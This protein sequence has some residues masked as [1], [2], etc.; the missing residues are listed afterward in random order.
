MILPLSG[1]SYLV[2]R[3][4]FA[5]MV[6][7]QEFSRRW[8]AWFM[9]MLVPFLAHNVW[10]YVFATAALLYVLRE[11]EVNA[12][13]L[14]FMLLFA[15]PTFRIEIPG[16]GMVNYL[17]HINH[18]RLLALLVLLP[19]FIWLRR[20]EGVAPVG[21]FLADKLIIAFIAYT[22]LMTL[23]GTT[24]TDTIRAAFLWFIDIFLP[25]YVAS[26]AV[27]SRAE[28]REVLLAFVFG[29]MAVS[30]VAFFE[31]LKGWLV[32]SPLSIALQAPMGMGD[33]VLRG[34]AV[35]ASATIGHPIALGYV[36]MVA[37]GMLFFLRSYLHDSFRRRAVFLLL[38]AGIFAA[39]SRGPWVGACVFLL[40]FALF[41]ER[42]AQALLKLLLGFMLAGIA[43]LLLPGG[44]K[45]IDMLP[46][47]GTVDAE[48]VEYRERLLEN[49]LVVIARNPWFGSVNYLQ[50]PEMISMFQGQG[51]IDVVN[52]YLQI[53]LEFGYVGLAL[54]VGFFLVVLQGVRGRFSSF[55]AFDREGRVL[56][57]MLFAV[58]A[59]TLV[60]IY[61]T[62]SIL[63]IPIVYW[64]LAGL[65]VAYLSQT[66]HRPA[67]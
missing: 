19:A 47:V 8:G 27:R 46:Y 14:Y 9:V 23:R 1:M 3:T 4:A 51:I 61:T 16:F 44:E 5:N 60:V 18:P 20:Q 28:M 17:F 6:L 65:G 59:A 30:M 26:R 64:S 31:N 7:P 66:M 45:L 57:A 37:L 63:S 54:F 39:M 42:P 41:D 13:A 35:R 40:V 67:A 33:Y 22:T 48:N 52:T 10:V 36:V 34:G 53:A 58:L 43:A 2:A 49:A 29:T 21:R 55:S 32:F 25:Y 38:I 15:A 56:G 24:L 50:A 12:L 62:S 11:K